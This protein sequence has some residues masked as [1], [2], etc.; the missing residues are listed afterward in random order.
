MQIAMSIRSRII[1]RGRKEPSSL[2]R[3]AQNHADAERSTRQEGI[4]QDH[5]FDA[6]TA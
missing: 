1:A 2:R 6:Q 3:A 4:L 5:W